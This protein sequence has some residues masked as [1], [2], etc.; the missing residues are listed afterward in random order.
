MPTYTAQITGKEVLRLAKNCT[1]HLVARRWPSNGCQSG[2]ILTGRASFRTMKYPQLEYSHA[3]PVGFS[4]GQT[5]KPQ[6][7][8]RHGRVSAL[9]LVQRGG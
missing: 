5:E 9:I 4:T 7:L 3:C 8:C 6:V 1:M 2:S